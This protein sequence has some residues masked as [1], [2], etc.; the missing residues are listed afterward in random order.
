MCRINFWRIIA[1]SFNLLLLFFYF[2]LKYF[3]DKIGGGSD[4]V[5]KYLP[6][7]TYLTLYS[8]QT[9]QIYLLNFAFGLIRYVVIDCFN[10][11]VWNIYNTPTNIPCIFDTLFISFISPIL[12]FSMMLL[13]DFL[14]IL[15]YCYMKTLLW[16]LFSCQKRCKFHVLLIKIAKFTYFWVIMIFDLKIFGGNFLGFLIPIILSYNYIILYNGLIFFQNTIEPSVIK[17]E[18]REVD[19]SK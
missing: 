11:Q 14:N 9:I 1:S 12:T 13:L 6:S 3:W 2:Q 19:I 17:I 10:E 5:Q 15:C 8:K 16:V 4:P 18:L 7:F